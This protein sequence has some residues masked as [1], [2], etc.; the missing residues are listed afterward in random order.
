MLRSAHLKPFLTTSDS[1]GVSCLQCNSFVSLLVLIAV[2]VVY[3]SPVSQE[4]YSY[5]RLNC[6]MVFL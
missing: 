6:D 2:F 1:G 5:R 4:S 3:L